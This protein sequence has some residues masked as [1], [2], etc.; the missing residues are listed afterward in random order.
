MLCAAMRIDAG[1]VH[2]QDMP[3]PG[4]LTPGNACSYVHGVYRRTIQGSA[5][6]HK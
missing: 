2:K 5:V 6:L 3:A 1:N 4:V